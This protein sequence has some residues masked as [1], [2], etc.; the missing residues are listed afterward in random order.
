MLCGCPHWGAFGEG[1][2]NKKDYSVFIGSIVGFILILVSSLIITNTLDKVIPVDYEIINSIPSHD[3]SKTV[4][5]Y[6]VNSGATSDFSYRVTI[7]SKKDFPDIDKEKYFF[8]YDSN[9]GNGSTVLQ[10]TWIDDYHLNVEYYN[11]IRSFTKKTLYNDIK[12]NYIV[13]D[14]N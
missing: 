13:K 4:Y 3:A 7:S 12:I 5:I 10:I 2:N 14:E 6:S 1:M 11:G 9:H 8:N